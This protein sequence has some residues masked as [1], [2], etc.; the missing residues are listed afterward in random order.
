M[1]R[2]S[3]QFSGAPHLLLARGPG[4]ERF[5][6]RPVERRRG[7]GGPRIGSRGPCAPCAL[8]S[9]G[10]KH[11]FV[12]GVLRRPL[13][14]TFVCACALAGCGGGSKAA[15]PTTE[16]PT[17]A[18]DAP[19]T[20]MTVDAASVRAQYAAAI[21]QACDAAGAAAT[22]VWDQNY[23]LIGK[24][25]SGMFAEVTACRATKVA[26]A[27]TTTVPRNGPPAGP[28]LLTTS[29]GWKYR[30]T[31]TFTSAGPST[32]PGGCVP[33]P[34]PGQTNVRFSVVVE[35]LIGDREAPSPVMQ[36]GANIG[37][38]GGVDRSITNIDTEGT[39]ILQLHV[40]TTPNNAPVIPGNDPCLQ[41]GD[42]FTNSATIPAGGSSQFTVVIGPVPDPLPSGLGLLVRGSR[43][44]VDNLDW[45]VPAGP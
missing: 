26:K 34:S 10:A 43:S 16:A 44:M 29:D 37:A 8:P 38:N 30:I 41:A 2:L 12:R 3:D 1:K 25:G 28:Q 15:A 36:F 33:T 42:L 5:R 21:K 11:R 18:T 19:T 6:R 23:A 4:G 40:E 39:N 9:R 24:T 32:S 35:N 14:L 20:T 31:V 7:S 17:I 27:P 45:T 13:I 22:P